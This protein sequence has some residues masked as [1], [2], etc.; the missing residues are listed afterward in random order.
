MDTTTITKAYGL[1]ISGDP[2]NHYRIY[3]EQGHR[4]TFNGEVVEKFVAQQDA[5]RF[6]YEYHLKMQ[7]P[8]PYIDPS[9]MKRSATGFSGSFSSYYNPRLT[10][11]THGGR[12]VRR[13]HLRVGDMAVSS[14]YGPR[15]VQKISQGGFAGQT[16]SITWEGG[17]KD[18][19]FS[20]IYPSDLLME[21][22]PEGW[23]R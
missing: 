11:P 19:P 10:W 5:E 20:E 7:D 14:H 3:D 9:T 18:R 1:T 8:E 23:T 16:T 2:Y 6:A 12:M 17:T 15:R 4:L 22:L 13:D 21:M